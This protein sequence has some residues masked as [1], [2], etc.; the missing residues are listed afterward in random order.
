M[1]RPGDRRDVCGSPEGLDK[2]GV[3]IA[4]ERQRRDIGIHEPAAVQCGVSEVA[5]LNGTE[6]SVALG[7]VRATEVN[8]AEDAVEAAVGEA[9]FE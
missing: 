3:P 9:G 5:I 1:T 6:V 7:A 8:A 4:R 2:H